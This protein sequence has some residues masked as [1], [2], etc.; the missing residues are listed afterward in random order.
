[1]TIAFYFVIVATTSTST[2]YQK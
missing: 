2:H 1:M